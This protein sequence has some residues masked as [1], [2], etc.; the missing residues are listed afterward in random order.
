MERRG[1]H[2]TTRLTETPSALRGGITPITGVERIASRSRSHPDE[3][4]TALMHHYTLENLRDCFKSLDG[5]KAL[6]VDRVTKETYGQHLE[7][8]LQELHHRLR[9]MSYRPQPARQVEIPKEDGTTRPLGI[10]CIEDKI[11]QEMTRRILEA[12]Y[13]PV[14]INTSYGFRPKRSCHDALR[15]LNE[16]VMTKPVNWVADIDLAQ[17]FNTMPHQE[18]LSVLSLRIQDRRFLRLISRMLQS[19]IQTPSGVM[20]GEVGSPQGSIVSPVI[21]NIFLDHV[22]DQWMIRIVTQHCRGYCGIIRYADGTPIQAYDSWGE[23]PLA[24]II[25][26]GA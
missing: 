20:Y 21:A 13:E 17:F 7:S 3:V 2:I 1:T 25:R 24:P 9:Q 19:G 8:N 14:F 15:Q 22:L 12:I 11:V 10:C 6:G 4:F 23:S 26:S 16:E 5:K 18:I